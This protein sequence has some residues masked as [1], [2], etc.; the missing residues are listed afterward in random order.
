M[1]VAGGKGLSMGLEGA[2]S[3]L[4]IE[5][6]AHAKVRWDTGATVW[7]RQGRTLG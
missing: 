5:K 6:T 2:D 3:E 4:H 7:I 1:N